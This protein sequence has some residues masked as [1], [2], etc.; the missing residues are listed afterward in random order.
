MAMMVRDEATADHATV[1]QVVQAAFG[2]PDEADLVDRLRREGDAVLS[3]VAIDDSEIAGHAMFSRMIAPFRAVG[4]A[5]IAVLPGQQGRGVG[6]MLVR[7]GLDR[8][9][10]QG[11]EGVFV[12]GD[13]VY[14]RRFGFDSALAA[15]F[16]SPYAGPSLMAV[17]LGAGLSARSGPIAY[18]PAFALL[19]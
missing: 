8:A 16:I 4:L 13:P 17:A 11:W 9:R 14:Y 7:E 15:G 19:R 6:G 2:R 10:L 5:P 3:L 1:R 12:L 18:A